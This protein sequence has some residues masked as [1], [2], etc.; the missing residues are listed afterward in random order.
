MNL[1]KLLATLLFLSLLGACTSSNDGGFAGGTTEDAG[2]IA[3]L[4]VAG[5][6][7]KGPFAKGSAVTVQGIDCKTL[8]FTNELF[9]GSV[10]SDKGEFVVD[11]VTLSST[12]AMF[13]VSGYYL[14]ELTGK[15]SSEKLTLHA[16]TNLKDRKNVN[17][18]VLTELEYERVIHLVTVE[19]MSF[20][21][22]KKQAE[23]EVLAS[24]NINS[25]IAKSE[26]LNILEKGEGNAAL[27]AVSVMAL[28][29]AK[30]SQIAE[31]LD[32]Y[33]AAI[34]QNGSLDGD[35]KK[36][37]ANWATSAAANGKLDTIRKNIESWGYADE[38]PPFETY[39]KAVANGDGVTLSSSSSGTK[40]G[41]TSSSSVTSAG[42]VTSSSSSSVSLSGVEGSSSSVT[43]SSSSS[44]NVTLSSSEGSSNNTK[45]S[46]LNPNIDYGEMTDPRDGQVYKTVKIDR[47]T[48]MA[49][50]LNYADSANMPSLKGRSWCYQKKAE[51]CATMGRL[52]SWAAAIDSVKLVTDA[53]SLD[54]GAGKTCGLRGPVQGVCPDGWHLPTKVEWV[55]MWE[56]IAGNEAWNV[57]G[58]L[59]KSRTGWNN[60]ANG[61]D[62]YGFSAIPAG[63]K[64]GAAYAY[65]GD[66][67]RFWSSTEN[68]ET[69]SGTASSNRNAY[70][71][72]YG[73]KDDP[74]LSGD[75]KTYGMSVRCVMNDG[76]LDWSIPKAS[77][78]NPDIDYGELTDSRDGKVYKTVKIGNQT[79]MAENLNYADSVKTPSLRGNSWCF[80]DNP[81]RCNVAGRLYTWTAAIDS[82][83]L[84][85]DSDNPRKC[86][87]NEEC[88]FTE[89]VRGIC[90]DGWHLPSRAEFDTLVATVGGKEIAEE[91]LRSRIGWFLRETD[92]D[93][94]GFSAIPVGR[95]LYD[96]ES[97]R[98]E[99][100]FS[101]LGVNFWSSNEEYTGAEPS[102]TIMAYVLHI[103][104]EE[105]SNP[106]VI[107]GKG[108]GYSIRCIKD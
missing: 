33:S 61:S 101:G 20:A 99:F 44:Q 107:V 16:L 41:M 26:D 46:Y 45:D 86:G 5:V 106:V 10:K 1:N 38:V 39:V 62:N 63:Y 92:S 47:R 89:K 21:D 80:G 29:D 105:N 73:P 6:T 91:N 68:E 12:C 28:A 51:N 108:A 32:E 56:A 102:P 22:A 96:R 103:S 35:T 27:L 52:Y 54:C 49:E 66:Y 57:A 94:Y 15:K 50:N 82:V 43:A 70:N 24:F 3:D 67:A 31:R 81:R 59:L 60:D 58:N 90:P 18:N 69:E 23:K 78:L 2:I 48:W 72:L 88:Q 104:Y 93:S 74:Q 95:R 13:E 42:S 7:Q 37:I 40:A 87:Y 79:W 19:K 64:A 65:L 85:K 4:N 55:D 98:V 100:L 11:S 17:I 30:E 8:K 75:D 77:Y 34:S 84:A 71:V 53:D 25:D 14:N 97:G 36:E 9:E 76:R 83:A